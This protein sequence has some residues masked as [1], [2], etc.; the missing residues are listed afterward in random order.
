MAQK[1]AQAEQAASSPRTSR[2]TKKASVGFDPAAAMP[3]PFADGM[4]YGT[5]AMKHWFETGQDMARFY[6]TRL[7]KDFSYLSEFGTCRTP[8]QGA[9]VWLR[10]ASE[11][12]RDYADQLDRVMKI[13]MN[14]SHKEAS[15]E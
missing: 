10:A 6:N 12:A 11:A 9:E 5:E 15:K 14:G 7:I 13:A 8:A 4:R 2:T 1:R 3:L